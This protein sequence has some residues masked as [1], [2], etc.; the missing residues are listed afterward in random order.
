[1]ESGTTT[2]CKEVVKRFAKREPTKKQ[3]LIARV[4]MIVSMTM[5]TVSVLLVIVS[6]TMSEHID[7]LARKIADH[8]IR[9]GLS[10]VSTSENMTSA[11]SVYVHDNKSATEETFIYTQM[12]TDIVLNTTEYHKFS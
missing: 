6:L 10:R 4:V 7:D 8:K 2:R 5:L 1:M 12:S 3:K 11:K 9:T